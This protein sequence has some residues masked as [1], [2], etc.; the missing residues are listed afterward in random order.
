[1]NEK[2]IFGAKM[3]FEEVCYLSWEKFEFLSERLAEKIEKDEMDFQ[4]IVSLVNGGLILGSVLSDYLKIPLHTI[5]T[6]RFRIGCKKSTE[7]IATGIIDGN[8]ILEGNVLVIKDFVN[9]GKT[10]ESVINKVRMEKYVE[11]VKS[12][13]LFRKVNSQFRPNYYAELTDKFIVF[14]YRINEF[15]RQINKKIDE[16]NSVIKEVHIQN[17]QFYEYNR[18]IEIMDRGT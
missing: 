16:F 13:V 4:N 7:I 6:Q 9:I 17:Y 14:P 12:A 8:T 5:H 11:N 3:D 10:L 18:K 2:L 1:M 15:F